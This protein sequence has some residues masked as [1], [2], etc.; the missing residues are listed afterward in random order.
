MAIPGESDLASAPDMRV[1]MNDAH[2]H[3]PSGD[4]TGLP[5][6]GTGAPSWTEDGISPESAQ[7]V[8]SNAINAWPSHLPPLPSQS[9]GADLPIANISRIMKRALP[10][11]GKIAKNAKECMQECVSELISFIT[12]EASDRCGSEKRKTINGDDI[13]YS[14]RVLGFDNY[15]Q[16]LKVYLS[17]YRQAQEE[18]PRQRR[19]R[20]T[21]RR[22]STADGLGPEGD[23]GTQ[24]GSQAG[25]DVDDDADDIESDEDPQD[26]E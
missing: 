3:D 24:T 7:L 23:T 18:N 1:L 11:N 2:A 9:A 22:A 14:L 6:V 17:R 4:A 13:L 19:R 21:K 15:E 8:S 12:S 26:G 5:D 10:D 16:V 20:S 25:D